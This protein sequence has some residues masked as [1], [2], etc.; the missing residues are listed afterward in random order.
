MQAPLAGEQLLHEAALLL[1]KRF[2][3]Q[4]EERQPL[5]KN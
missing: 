4:L 1:S 5:I 3:L 2:A